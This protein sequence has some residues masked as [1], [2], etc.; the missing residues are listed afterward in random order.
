MINISNA[1]IPIEMANL[2]HSKVDYIEVLRIKTIK[3]ELCKSEKKEQKI[4]LDDKQKNIGNMR[5][6]GR[7]VKTWSYA[8]GERVNT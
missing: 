8:N 2:I 5:Y 6:K 3:Q 4:E 7:G 1:C